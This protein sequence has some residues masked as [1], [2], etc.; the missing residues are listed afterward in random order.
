MPQLPLRNFNQLVSDQQASLQASNP[1]FSD[2]SP[3]SPLLALIE[4]NAGIALWMQYLTYL[5]LRNTRMATAEGFDLDTFGQQFLFGRYPAIAASGLVLFTRFTSLNAV[6]VPVNSL[7]RTSDGSLTFQ[8]IADTTNSLYNPATKTYDI[9]AGTN[10]FSAL[11]QCVTAGAIGNISANTLTR[12][13]STLPVSK[14]T[15]PA[16]F[17]NG[18]DEETDA[19]FRSR[20]QLYINTRS[21]ATVKAIEDA[22]VN[23]QTG[24]TYTIQENVAADGSR[25]PGN[26]LIYYDDGT[27]NPPIALTNLLQTNVENVRAAGVSFS[28]A[29]ATPVPISISFATKFSTGFNKTQLVGQLALALENYINTIPVGQAVVYTRLYQ[30]IYDSTPGLFEASNLLINN[31]AGDLNITLAQVARFI[32]GQSTMVI[33]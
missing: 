16:P 33:D 20:F 7:L 25:L 2:L 3:G 19:S 14:V 13:A 6:K 5:A 1:N 12:I 17:I 15:N 29:P 22:I 24:L 8:V 26:V 11:V 23:T 21:R 30:I 10:S 18:V 31:T 32:P 28:L 27:G 4:A 9:P